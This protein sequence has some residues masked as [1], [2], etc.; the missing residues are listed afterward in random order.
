M[1]AIVFALCA[2][3]AAGPAGAHETGKPHV[4]TGRGSRMKPSRP[5]AKARHR[6]RRHKRRRHKK[7]HRRHR[8]RR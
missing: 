3:F 2:L 8:R 6:G 4:H 1:R 5:H 7:S